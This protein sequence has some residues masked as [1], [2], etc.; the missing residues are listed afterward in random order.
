LALARRWAIAASATR[1]D[2]ATSPV[3][4][5]PSNPR[6]KATWASWEHMKIGRRRSSS[7]VTGSAAGSGAPSGESIAA[8]QQIAATGLTPQAIDRAVAIQP[9]GF[10]GRP[11]AGH[12]AS[13]TSNAS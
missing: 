3:E 8:F 12:R 5:A 1:K 10:G 11:W 13:A 6:V 4:S 7:T 9:P 2:L